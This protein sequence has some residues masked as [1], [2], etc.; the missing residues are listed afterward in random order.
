MVLGDLQDLM[1]Q[2]PYAAPTVFNFYHSD[3]RPDSFPERM[4]APEFEIFD[5]PRIVN[6]MNG[7]LDEWETKRWDGTPEISL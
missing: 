5:P 2:L 1:G 7:R 4:A 3:Y 6:F